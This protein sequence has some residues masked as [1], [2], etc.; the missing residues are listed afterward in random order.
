M[1]IFLE[2][3]V[4][5]VCA[6]PQMDTAHNPGIPCTSACSLNLMKYTHEFKKKEVGYSMKSD[7]VQDDGAVIIFF[8]VKG[9]SGLLW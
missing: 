3:R 6:V 9:V 5:G 4:S 8:F 1:H 7:T 2:H